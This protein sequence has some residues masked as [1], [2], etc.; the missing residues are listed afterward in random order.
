MPRNQETLNAAGF[1]VN[2]DAN[3]LPVSIYTDKGVETGIMISRMPTA[4]IP[5]WS[6]ALIGRVVFDTTTNKL[7]VAGAAAWETVTSA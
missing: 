7:K 5:A 1:L 3:G 4:S 2:F 6:A